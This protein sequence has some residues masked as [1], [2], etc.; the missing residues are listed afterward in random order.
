VLKQG[1]LTGAPGFYYSSPVAADDKLF[2]ISEEGKVTVLK[3]GANWEILAVNDLEDGCN[4][5]PAI[6]DGRIYLRTHT[7]LWCFAQH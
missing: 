1:R 2:A 3:P 6:V 4:A 7:A 5:T